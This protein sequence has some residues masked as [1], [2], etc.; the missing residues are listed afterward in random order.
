MKNRLIILRIIFLYAFNR[1]FL[2]KLGVPCFF[3]FINIKH[4]F[5]YGKV[6][7]IADHLDKRIEQCSGGTKRKLSFLISMIGDSSTIIMD[8]PSRGMDPAARHRNKVEQKKK[9]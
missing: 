6:L 5:S 9:N 7:K 3:C 1:H 4:L 8:E 2:K